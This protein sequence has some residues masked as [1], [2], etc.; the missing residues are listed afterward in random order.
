MSGEERDRSPT[1]IPIDDLPWWW[2]EIECDICGSVW[3]ETFPDGAIATTCPECGSRTLLP[4]T[5][6]E[7][8]TDDDDDDNNNDTALQ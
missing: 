6:G 7:Y 2:S 1:Q 4:L 3:H 5:S 8:A